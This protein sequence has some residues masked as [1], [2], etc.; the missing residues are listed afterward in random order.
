LLTG[1][2]LVAL[3]TESH[4]A[5]EAMI[6]AVELA[7]EYGIYRNLAVQGLAF[8]G[9]HQQTRIMIPNRMRLS[10][11]RNKSGGIDYRYHACEEIANR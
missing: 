2:E 4:R 6:E 5:I 10:I 1:L 11:Y 8:A 7:K 3:A 9:I